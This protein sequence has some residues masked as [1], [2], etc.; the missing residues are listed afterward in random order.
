VFYFSDIVKEVYVKYPKLYGEMYR[1]Y[2][3]SKCYVCL[4][5]PELAEVMVKFI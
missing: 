3:G 5:S 2:A 4:V 1:F